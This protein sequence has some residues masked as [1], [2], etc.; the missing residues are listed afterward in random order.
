M[1][2]HFGLGGNRTT[3]VRT[4]DWDCYGLYN[5]ESEKPGVKEGRVQ[6]LAEITGVRGFRGPE[7]WEQRTRASDGWEQESIVYGDTVTCPEGRR[8]ATPSTTQG[9]PNDQRDRLTSVFVC[10]H[11][12][13]WEA[14]RRPPPCDPVKS[15]SLPRTAVPLDPLRPFLVTGGTYL[16]PVST[17]IHYGSEV[18]GD[19]APDLGLGPF[20]TRGPVPGTPMFLPVPPLHFLGTSCPTVMVIHPE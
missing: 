17:P 19:S 18:H 8:S 3:S 4:K 20:D 10:L 15:R 1:T 7:G 12:C 14:C 13:D 16:R 11:R 5:K 9:R 6:E 2:T